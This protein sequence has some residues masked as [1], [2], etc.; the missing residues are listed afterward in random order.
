[1]DVET[2]HNSEEILGNVLFLCDELAHG[3]ALVRGNE[4]ALGDALVH[5]DKL[6]HGDVCDVIAKWLIFFISNLVDKIILFAKTL[7]PILMLNILNNLLYFL[8]FTSSVENYFRN[9][10][11][12]TSWSIYIHIEL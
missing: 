1:M 7:T 10:L 5:D 2:L 9:E 12:H 11:I 4:L 3:D 6:A 8:K